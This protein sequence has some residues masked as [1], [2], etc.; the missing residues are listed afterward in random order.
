[1]RLD[2]TAAA[3]DRLVGITHFSA[4]AH[5]STDRAAANHPLSG[6]NHCVFFF[7][8]ILQSIYWTKCEVVTS[9]SHKLKESKVM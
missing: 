3:A 8:V 5:I 1:M 6:L 4:V 7:S 9:A 2:T